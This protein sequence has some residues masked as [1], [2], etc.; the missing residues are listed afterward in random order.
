MTESAQDDV[1][2]SRTERTTE[3]K[4]ILYFI[5]VL[6]FIAIVNLFFSIESVDVDT[7]Q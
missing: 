1:P 6:F 5:N 3:V 7:R 2:V 4:T